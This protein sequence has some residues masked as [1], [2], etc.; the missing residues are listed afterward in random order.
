M[1][2]S[3]GIRRY[4]IVVIFYALKIWNTNILRTPIYHEGVR[5][6]RV[7]NSGAVLCH[8]SNIW[9]SKRTNLPRGAQYLNENLKQIIYII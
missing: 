4:K 9:P 1:Y 2:T 7:G 3:M 6:G 5:A 8:K